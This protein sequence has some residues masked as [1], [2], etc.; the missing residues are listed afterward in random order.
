M[1]SKTRPGNRPML[2][3]SHMAFLQIFFPILSLLGLACCSDLESPPPTRPQFVDVAARAGVTMINISGK[4]EKEH[5]VEAK[6]GGGGGFIDYDGDGDL[7]IYAIS[8][9][10]FN[11]PPPGERATNVLYRNNGDGS[12]TDV[13]Q[14]VGVGDDGWGMGCAA[15]DYDNDGHID[16]YVTNYGPNVLYHNNGD[17]S[18]TDVTQTADVGD[19]RWGTGCA[20]GDYDGDGDLDIFV[21]NYV[22]FDRNFVPRDKSFCTWR[23]VMVFYG[24]RGLNGSGDVLYRNDGDGS[25]TDISA[26]AG[27]AD[28]THYFGFA[29]RAGDYDDDGDLDLYIANDSTPNYLYLNEGGARFSNVSFISGTAYTEDGRE[30]GGMGVTAGD[31]DNDGDLDLCVTNFSYDNDTLYRNDGNGF[32]TDVSF[33]SGIGD[34]TWMYVGWGIEFLDYDNDGDLDIFVA[35][36]HAYPQV[37]YHDLG[38]TYPQSNQLFEND[39][40]GTF[41]EVTLLVGPGLQ[42]IKSSRGAAVGDYDND[43]DLDI[44][45]ANMDDSPSLLRNDGGNRNHWLNVKL[46]GTHCNRDAI[47]ARATL[48]AGDLIQVREVHAG[49]SF[50]SQSDLRLHFGLGDRSRVDRLEIRWPGGQIEVIDPVPVDRHIAVQ[51]GSGLL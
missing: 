15:A 47:G 8:G 16:L 33:T 23:G 22:D 26:L 50:L 46:I 51:E 40:D 24:P 34:L 2:L 10:R 25:F 36:G 44:F 18:F 21:A 4:I 11:P 3:P 42:V 6:G 37:K 41:T 28:S 12:F 13:T 1:R 30:Q 5:I 20:F 19:D 43:G 49:G 27:V 39:G 31:Y 17:G 29:V 45:V 32:F 7:D 14:T 48:V 9:T 38:T 35:N